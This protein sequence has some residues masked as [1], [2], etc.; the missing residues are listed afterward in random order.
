ME[1]EG[2]RESK[3]VYFEENKRNFI[4]ENLAKHCSA[5]GN[6]NELLICSLCLNSFQR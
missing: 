2:A 5:S 6:T 4:L 1:K 3:S